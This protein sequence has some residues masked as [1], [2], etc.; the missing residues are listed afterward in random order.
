MVDLALLVLVLVLLVYVV[1]NILLL[2]LPSLSIVVVVPVEIPVLIMSAKQQ[3]QHAHQPFAQP[4]EEPAD[5]S[6]TQAAQD[7]SPAEPAHPDK[8]VPTEHALLHHVTEPVFH[9]PKHATL[10]QI[11]VL[12]PLDTPSLMEYVLL[13]LIPI[14]VGSVILPAFLVVLLSLTF[15]QTPFPSLVPV[16]PLL[17][18]IS[19]ALPLLTIL[20]GLKLLLKSLKPLALLVSVGELE[21]VQDMQM[22]EYTFIPQILDYPT[23]V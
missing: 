12:V 19:L 4:T 2:V 1:L 17:S 22:M 20:P 5:H 11:L 3:H 15:L 13:V 8:H 10:L 23:M 16:L 18:S 21:T 9:L 7:P 6:Q 14:L